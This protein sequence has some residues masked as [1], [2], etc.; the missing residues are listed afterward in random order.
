[1]LR[2]CPARAFMALACL[3]TKR[4]S[5]DCFGDVGFCVFRFP[6]VV[7]V[8][9]AGATNGFVVSLTASGWEAVCFRRSDVPSSVL[10]MFDRLSKDL[11]H[12]TR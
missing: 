11:S 12:R 9:A 3:C 1:M 4:L 8:A 6:A 10:S 5:P 7:A 2:L